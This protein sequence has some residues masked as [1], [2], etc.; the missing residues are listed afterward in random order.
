MT[1]NRLIK[2]LALV[3]TIFALSGCLGGTIAQQIARSVFLH[4]ADKVTAS[5]MDASEAREKKALANRPLKDTP[6]DPYKIAFL[7][8]KFENVPLEIEPLPAVNS[9]E[10][11][12]AIQFM[13]S[14][15]LVEVEIWSVLIGD[16]K[17]QVLERE[18]LKGSLMIPPKNEWSQWQVAVGQQANKGPSQDAAP[19]YFLVPPE[20]GK[21][22][23][24]NK[25]IVEYAM[26]NAQKI[27]SLSVARYAV[28]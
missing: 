8:S 28:Q 24:G 5:A 11:E 26:P 25:A 14:T 6:P 2:I 12:T 1:S 9:A 21:M 23:S 27:E 10:D 19:I 15:Q 3:S 20:F 16:E 4:A 22:R 18:R 17:Q 7:T 13:A